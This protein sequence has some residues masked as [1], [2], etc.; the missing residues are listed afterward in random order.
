MPHSRTSGHR[1]GTMESLSNYRRVSL[2][3]PYMA[4]EPTTFH[5]FAETVRDTPLHRLWTGQS[6]KVDSGHLIAAS[7]GMGTKV[8]IGL[9]VSL[10]PLRHPYETALHARSLALLTGHAPVIGLG[11]A[12]PEF[13]AGLH[14]APYS[15]PLAVASEYVRIVRALLR[16]EA[17]AEEGTHFHMHGRLLPAESPG[18]EIGLGVLRPGMAGV[19]GRWADAAV[20]FLSPPRYLREAIVP[21][22][23]EASRERD[24][25]PRLVT[26]AHFVVERAGR[27]CP[28]AIAPTITT[29]IKQAH[30]GHVLEK[31]G[32]SIDPHDPL[33]AAER[34][35]GSGVVMS[36]TP[37][38][39]VSAIRR[40]HASGVDEVVLN[41]AGVVHTEGIVAGLADVNEV[42]R[43]FEGAEG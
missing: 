22:I 35:I 24:R 39:I 8:P 4:E 26:I 33:A 32:I 30:Y 19:A 29:H 28:R 15:S 16:G 18:A 1:T 38:R 40:L 9:G 17:L 13:V 6:L 10:L 34:L 21:R 43:A 37:E 14:G 3:Y 41:P 2:F 36:G 23:R 12:T 25:P 42:V 11:T 5:R 31:A 20:T 27:D 7:V